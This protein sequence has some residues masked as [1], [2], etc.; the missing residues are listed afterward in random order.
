M[1]EVEKLE[2]LIQEAKIVNRQLPQIKEVAEK[3]KNIKFQFDHFTD[4][5]DVDKLEKQLTDKIDKLD[6]NKLNDSI[7]KIQEDMQYSQEKIQKLKE[8]V[9]S[10][11]YE[12]EHIMRNFYGY[13]SK[14]K[15]KSQNFRFI[16]FLLYALSYLLGIFTVIA[17]LIYNH[18]IIAVNDI[19]EKLQKIQS[20]SISI[21]ATTLIFQIILPV[22]FVA[23]ILYLIYD[24]IACRQLEQKSDD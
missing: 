22:I 16:N 19:P 18:I 11:V 20:I 15:N 5:I 1:T 23:G 12:A 24:A 8:D 10:Q 2:R 3:L 4:K 9:S 6:L 14:L 7:T 13:I 17:Y 21:D